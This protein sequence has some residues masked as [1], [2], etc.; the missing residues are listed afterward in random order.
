VDWNLAGTIAAGI[1]LANVVM[2]V[3]ALLKV[4]LGY[5]SRKT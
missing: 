1:I 3:W 2:Q 4:V 5:P